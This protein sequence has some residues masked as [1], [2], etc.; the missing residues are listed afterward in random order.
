MSSLR[1][2]SGTDNHG[3]NSKSDIS[4]SRFYRTVQN[5]LCQQFRGATQAMDV[6]NRLSYTT[7][8][9]R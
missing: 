7:Q 2:E 5:I 9:I 6:A 4:N 1:A 3:T 8:E